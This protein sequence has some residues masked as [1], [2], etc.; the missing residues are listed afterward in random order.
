MDRNKTVPQAKTAVRMLHSFTWAAFTV[1]ATAAIAGLA[2][3]SCKNALKDPQGEELP[4]SISAADAVVMDVLHQKIRP[5]KFG[6]ADIPHASPVKTYQ[7][8]I[9]ITHRKNL[10]LIFF[11]TYVT[12]ETSIGYLYASRSLEAKDEVSLPESNTGIEVNSEFT[13]GFA[14]TPS[15]G[16]PET[17]PLRQQIDTHWWRASW[18][19]QK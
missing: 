13:R 11:P 4:F 1:I 19:E 7:N 2:C 16:I 3:C 8:L 5:D 14:P 18:R 15:A 12:R 9:T 6:I 17:I 10:L